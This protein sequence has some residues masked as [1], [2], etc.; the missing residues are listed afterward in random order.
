[1]TSPDTAAPAQVTVIVPTTA[2]LS[3]R[4]EIM[5]CVQSIRAS[6]QAAVHIITVVNGNR[7]DPDICAWLQAQPDVQ[8]VYVEM[9]SAPN[10]VLEGRKLVATPYFSFVDDDDEY[11]PGATD[12]KLATLSAA[13][14]ADLVVT[15]T[16]RNFN[17]QD[18]LLYSHLAEVP[19]QPLA[20]LFVANW[21]NNGNALFRSATIGV[22][23]FQ[24]Y[25]PYAEWTWLAF[26]LI[27]DHKRVLT[28]EQPTFRVHC[29]KGSLS[30]SD[31]YVDYYLPLYESMLAAGLPA[32]IT[33][34]VRRRMGAAQHHHSV[35]ALEGGRWREALSWH[36]CSL[37][38]PGGLQY[39]SYTRH[40]LRYWVRGK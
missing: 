16:Y 40:L 35:R 24:D 17:N 33:R 13:P 38:L 37:L 2:Q 18:E 39:L 12:L 27:M 23:Y 11:L 10:A 4:M 36:W 32:D 22:D 8:Y 3:R 31:A 7:Y 25:R 20:S 26:K 29:T 30:Q 15:N 34:L 21:L 9:P 6:S 5:R 1:M 28:L 14:Q 19:A